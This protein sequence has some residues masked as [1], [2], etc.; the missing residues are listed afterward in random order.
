MA[1]T[2]GGTSVAWQLAYVLAGLL[3]F[4]L[5]V[6]FFQNRTL[7]VHSPHGCYLPGIAEVRLR[8]RE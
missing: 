3:D 7:R 1:L 6:V 8:E 2:F 5:F 4:P